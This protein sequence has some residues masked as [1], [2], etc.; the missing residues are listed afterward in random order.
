MSKGKGRVIGPY[1]FESSLSILSYVEKLEKLFG[2][3]T[4][5]VLNFSDISI[6]EVFN[7]VRNNQSLSH[8]NTTL[9]EVESKFIFN[10]VVNL[11]KFLRE[12][13]KILIFYS[14]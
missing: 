5:Y 14:Q 9:N 13:K 8:D 6:L 11:I 1:F 7:D 10:G 4:G 2:M 3:G 12:I